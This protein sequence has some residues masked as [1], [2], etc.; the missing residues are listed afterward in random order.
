M[1]VHQPP[2]APGMPDLIMFYKQ[3]NKLNLA[4]GG[5]SGNYNM[6]M[7]MTSAPPG[8]MN[9]ERQQQMFNGMNGAPAHAQMTQ[10]NNI[11]NSLAN[12]IV[13]GLANMAGTTPSGN[14]GGGGGGGN[15]SG[16]GGGNVGNGGSPYGSLGDIAALADHFSDLSI[17]TLAME[18]KP[19]KRPPP[20]Y[21]CHL[22]FQKG[23]YIKDCPQVGSQKEGANCAG[24]RSQAP[25]MGQLRAVSQLPGRFE[26]QITMEAWR[27][28]TERARRN[29]R[30]IWEFEIMETQ[31]DAILACLESKDEF[32]GIATGKGKSLCYQ[33]AFRGV[34]RETKLVSIV[35]PLRALISDQARPKGEGLTPYQGKKRCFGEYKCPKCK[36]KWMS[37]NSWANMGQE[38]I[39]CRINVYPH[40]QS[41]LAKTDGIS[42]F[43]LSLQRPLEKP[44]GLDVSDQSKE[45]PQHLCEKCKALGYY[46][47]R[48]Q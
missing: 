2:P 25:V 33:I 8:G 36:R 23:H 48:V 7:G 6:N 17:N 28:W 41:P 38:C 47:R 16:G 20:S 35:S 9:N 19:T 37:G 45:H 29:F 4:P 12:G 26:F 34:C 22:C 5:P 14:M 32:V 42:T 31:L 15:Y 24:V 3:F 46:C 39:K 40:K 43:R 44:D 18:R 30:A 27:W 1:D 13:T 10:M 21:L 11:N